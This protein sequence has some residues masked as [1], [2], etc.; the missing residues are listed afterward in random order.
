MKLPFFSFGN[1][2]LGL[3]LGGGAVLGAAHIGALKAIEEHNIPISYIAGTSIGA[4]VGAL[5]AFG[6][7]WHELRDIAM[8][9]EWINISSLSFSG[10][11][12]LSNC[13]ICNLVEK[14]IGK[15]KIEDAPIP[16]AIVTTDLTTG[17]RKILTDGDLGKAIQASTC[18]PGIYQ[19]VE[20]GEAL[21]VDGGL[22]ENV[23][24]E[25]VRNLGAKKV[26]GV[27]LSGYKQYKKPKNAID[28]L[29]LSFEITLTNLTHIKASKADMRIQP[30][31]SSFNMVDTNQV[32]KL[33]ETGYQKANKEL[34]EKFSL[35][36]L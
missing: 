4:L 31:L 12:L 18:I 23:P 19:P 24:V 17:K 11:G 9:M 5:F 34:K 13:K 29:L 2:K 14:V 6:K 25:A 16:V 15:S 8:N 20:Y 1:R 33:I 27:D 35:Q 36:F 3:A 21:L 26:I 7:P 28:T 30:N 22:T 10:P 32:A